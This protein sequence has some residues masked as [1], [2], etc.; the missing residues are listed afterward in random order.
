M[1]QLSVLAVG[2]KWNGS[3]DGGGCIQTGD[4][5]HGKTSILDFR[6][7]SLGQP[8]FTLVLAKIERIVKSGNH[9][10]VVKETR[11]KNN[12]RNGICQ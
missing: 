9:V 12:I 10:L 8:G 2:L 5:N 4:S 11:Q 1:N 7:A 6:R 3:W